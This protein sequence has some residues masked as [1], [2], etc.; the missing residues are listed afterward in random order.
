M[1]NLNSEIYCLIRKKKKMVMEKNEI[2]LQ[3]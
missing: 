3:K 1:I 2:K